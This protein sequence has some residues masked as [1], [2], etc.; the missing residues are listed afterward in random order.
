[1]QAMVILAV[2]SGSMLG[3]VP[4]GHRVAGEAVG[5]RSGGAVSLSSDGS[6]VA[7]E[8]EENDVTGT[9]SGHVRI[10]AWDGTT[11]T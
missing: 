6:V 11:W 2:T 10:Y 8:S 1:M 5:D 7:I 3:T 9:S 4:P